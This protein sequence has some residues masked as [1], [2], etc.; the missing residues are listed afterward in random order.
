[1]KCH[2]IKHQNTSLY[3]LSPPTPKRCAYSQSF[4]RYIHLCCGCDFVCKRLG[5]ICSVPHKNLHKHVLI[6]RNLTRAA[7]PYEIKM[8]C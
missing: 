7:S 5:R 1:M 2:S 6:T 8:F 4:R 3:Q